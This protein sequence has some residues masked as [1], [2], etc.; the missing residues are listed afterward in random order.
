[1]KG[2]GGVVERAR[3]VVALVVEE[4]AAFRAG[5]GVA[6]GGGVAAGAEGVGG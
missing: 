5:V 6:G 3:R 1:M 2:V 4:E